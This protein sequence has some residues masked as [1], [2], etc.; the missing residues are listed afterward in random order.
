MHCIGVSQPLQA[1]E[2][3][4][5]VQVVFFFNVDPV[6]LT[7]SNHL[8]IVYRLG[9][10][11]RYP[12][13]KWVRKADWVTIAQSPFLKNV[14][15]TTLFTRP[16]HLT[17]SLVQINDVLHSSYPYLLIWVAIATELLSNEI[18]A[19]NGIVYRL[20]ILKHSTV[21]LIIYKIYAFEIHPF[22]LCRTFYFIAVVQFM[23]S[24]FHR[25]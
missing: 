23:H 2:R 17:M 8:K 5:A 22:F 1:Y 11:A 24:V 7:E 20:C 13:K 4:L 14:D 10:L 12:S 9:T 18:L 16:L 3:S 15:E 25:L 6:A 21:N 19:V